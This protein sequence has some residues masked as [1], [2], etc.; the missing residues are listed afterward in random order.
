MITLEN[1]APYMPYG[2]KFKSEMDKPFDEHGINPIH[3]CNGIIELFGDFCLNAKELNDAYAVQSCKP[4]LRPMDLTKPITIDGK[5]VI[6]IVELAKIGWDEKLSAYKIHPER[7]SLITNWKSLIYPDARY[8]SF[9]CKT[10]ENNNFYLGVLDSEINEI[11]YLSPRNQN[12]LFK[13]LYTNF[14]DVD[15]LIEKG[16]AID[17]STLEINLYNS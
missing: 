13:W 11:H 14:F 12:K 1:I 10:W 3:T 5:E 4:I 2:L 17:V 15:G 7:A 8:I 9:N 16:L 6:P